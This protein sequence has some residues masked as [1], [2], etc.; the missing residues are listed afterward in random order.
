MGSLIGRHPKQSK[1]NWKLGDDRTGLGLSEKKSIL[2]VCSRPRLWWTYV[3]GTGVRP[4]QMGKFSGRR[5]KT[6][7]LERRQSTR[8]L[9]TNS[10]IFHDIFGV[11]ATVALER[12][13]VS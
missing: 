3:P 9:Y 7:T 12:L 2:P 13:T 1:L 4:N 5:A 10:Y 6:K 8:I 11:A